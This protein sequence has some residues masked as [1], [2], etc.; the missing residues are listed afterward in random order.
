MVN[1]LRMIS[2]SQPL[3]QNPTQI[4]PLIYGYAAADQSGY[5]SIQVHSDF[6]FSISSSPDTSGLQTRWPADFARDLRHRRLSRASG[7]SDRRPLIEAVELTPADLL[8]VIE[9]AAHGDR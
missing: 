1:E 7:G 5:A 3:S 6:G 2:G 4:E 8:A 9:H